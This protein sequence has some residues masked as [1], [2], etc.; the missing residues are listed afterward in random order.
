MKPGAAMELVA[1]REIRERFRARSFKVSLI[2]S[3]VIAAGAVVAPS[4]LR[5]P[6]G[7]VRVGIVGALPPSARAAMAQLP[8]VVGHPV[9]V[10]AEPDAAAAAQMVRTNQ[11][12]AA[13]TD[14]AILV[15]QTPQPGDTAATARLAGALASLLGEDATFH[16]VGLSGPQITEIQR[17]PPAPIHALLPN[18]SARDR[19]RITTFVGIFLLYAFVN[20]YGAWVLAGVVEEKSTRVVEVLLATLRP[21]HL[22]AGKILGIGTLAVLQGALVAAAAFAAASATGAHVL[23]GAAGL[24]VVEMVG[25][26]VL[27]YAFYSSIYGAAGAL[28]GR[29]EEVQNVSFPIGLPLLVAYFTAAGSISGGDVSPFAKLLSFLP[30]T[31]PISMPMRIAAGPVPGWEIALSIAMLLAGTVVAIRVAGIVYNRAIL[32]TGKRI[33]W[34]QA[35]RAGG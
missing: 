8:Q 26:F 19:Q 35:I 4:A 33:T 6:S 14:G 24:T 2:I 3:V 18:R 12:S 30:P 5:G 28:V 7:P 21:S 31:A 34:R 17:A 25:W 11:I 23:E 10:V 29:Q 1:R 13:I 9:L 32:R 15:R 16:A 20:Q 27:G 22:L